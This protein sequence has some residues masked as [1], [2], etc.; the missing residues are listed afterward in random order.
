MVS[1]Y[2]LMPVV[3]GIIISF[4]GYVLAYGQVI[5]VNQTTPCFLNYNQTSPIQVWDDCGMDE[6]WLRAS[7]IGFEY[8]TG[9]FFSMFFALL[10]MLFTYIKYHK[11][12]YPIMIGITMLPIT[13][14]L[15]P[16]N[17]VIFAVVMVAVVIGITLLKILKNQTSEFQ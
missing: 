1:L 12:L 15:F 4:S 11:A 3:I 16:S 8:V 5:I 13:F 2:L 14:M 10:L 9:G 17:F 7:L 6:D